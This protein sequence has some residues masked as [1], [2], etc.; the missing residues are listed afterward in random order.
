[1]TDSAGALFITW[2]L[3]VICYFMYGMID[4]ADALFIAWL[5]VLM[6]YLLHDWQCWRDIYY[7]HCSD[8][9]CLTGIVLNAFQDSESA[10]SEDEEVESNEEVVREVDTECTVCGG[11][12]GLISCSSCPSSFHIDCHNPPLRRMP[13]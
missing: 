9:H 6:D 3:F 2:Q 7:V 1:M 11:D 10:G 13:R 8:A 5:S 12:E 4:T